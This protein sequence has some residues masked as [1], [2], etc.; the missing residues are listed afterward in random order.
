[1]PYIHLNK[2]VRKIDYNQSMSFGKQIQIECL[3]KST[4]SADHV[5]CTVSLGV[6]KER[7]LSLFD[8]ILPSDK[9]DS[10]EGL[11]IGTVD[12]IYVEFEKP[13]WSD[14]WNGFS[15]LWKPEQLKL[16]REDPINSEWLEGLIGFFRVNYQ[17]NILCGWIS[18]AMARKMEQ[19][20][21]DDVKV[22]VE[23]IF[24]MFLKQHNI[25]EI[26]N[27]LRYNAFEL[28]RN[29]FESL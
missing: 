18:G 28:I 27:I 11:S 10:I 7:H 4:Y 14:D 16:C 12:K 29:S 17:P 1:M 26:K 22:G 24:H 3:D 9:F 21:I 23:K 8:P 15:M 2:E 6:L 5:I 20:D 13:F 19:I 25:T